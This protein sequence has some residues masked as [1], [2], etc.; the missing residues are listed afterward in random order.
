MHIPRAHHGRR[1]SLGASRELVA[2]QRAADGLRAEL[3]ARKVTLVKTIARRFGSEIPER[4]EL[5]S[6]GNL[7]LICCGDRFDAARGYKFSTYA[8]RAIWSSFAYRAACRVR[9]RR[10]APVAYVPALGPNDHIERLRERIEHDIVQDLREVISDNSAR[11]TNDEQRVLRARFQLSSV[12]GSTRRGERW[13]LQRVGHL[14]GV[15]KEHV[16][17]IQGGALC[18]PRAILNKRLACNQGVAG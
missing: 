17:P 8:C 12:R 7:T 4:S 11:L 1:P 14:L 3:V 15:S 16:R 9:E 10:L 18:K 5:E 2:W 6:E 13:T